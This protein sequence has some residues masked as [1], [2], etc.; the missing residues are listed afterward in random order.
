LTSPTSVAPAARPAASTP[1]GP[2]VDIFNIGCGRCRTYRQHP[3]GARRRRLQLRWWSLS[4]LPP[5]PPRGPTI[6]VSNFGGGRC[7]TYR[8]HP[9]GGPPSMSPTSVVVAAGPTTSTP[10]GG[11]P[12]TSPTFGPLAPS[13]QGHECA[14]MRAWRECMGEGKAACSWLCLSERGAPVLA[15]VSRPPVDCGPQEYRKGLAP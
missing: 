11:P 4:D 8:Q 2:T 6:D 10:Q 9:L 13:M 14:G 3:Q 1:R 7:R 15:L 5:A 12:S